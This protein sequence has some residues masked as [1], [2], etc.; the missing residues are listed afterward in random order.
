[1]P[2]AHTHN[3]A[4]QGLLESPCLWRGKQRQHHSPAVPS[5]H[6]ELDR[7]LPGGGWP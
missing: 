5:G 4:L 2:P 1:M 7:H 6:A 3:A